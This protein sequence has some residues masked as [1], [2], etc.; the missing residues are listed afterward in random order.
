M[1]AI[2]THIPSPKPPNFVHALLFMVA[3]HAPL[4]YK[5]HPAV[6]SD[7]VF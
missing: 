2:Q 4:K 3:S 6:L 5:K 1:A 7:R